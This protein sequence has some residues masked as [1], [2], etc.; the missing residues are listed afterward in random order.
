VPKYIILMNYTNEGVRDIKNSAARIE[1]STKLWE[2]MGGKTLGV[3]LTMGQ[4][5]LV[6]IGEGPSDEAAAA[7]ALKLGALGTVRTTSLKAFSLDEAKGIIGN[8]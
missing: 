4:Y 3:Y 1:Q 2:S 8:V 6:A 5:D 7:F